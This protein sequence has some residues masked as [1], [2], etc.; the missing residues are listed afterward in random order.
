MHL[1]DTSVWIHA[2]RRRRESSPIH[3]LLRPLTVSGEAAMTEWIILELMTGIRANENNDVFLRRLQSLPLL[4]FDESKWS[5]VWALAGQLRK[6]G[7]SPTASDCFIATVAISHSVPL[8]HC[9]SDF[10]LIAENSN[11]ETVD[12]TAQA[13]S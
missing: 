4:S 7:I 10:E 9:D 2:F 3:E 11:L 8:I 5:A 13:G 12:W 6:R 1:V